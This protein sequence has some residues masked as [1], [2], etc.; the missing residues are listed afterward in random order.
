MSHHQDF[1][2]FVKVEPTGSIEF[3][4]EPVQGVAV[5]RAGPGVDGSHG[6]GRYTVK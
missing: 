2:G 1:A 5:G 3:S 4:G 6:V